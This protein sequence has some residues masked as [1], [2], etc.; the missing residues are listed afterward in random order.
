MNYVIVIHVS[1]GRLYAVSPGITV[2]ST[3][4]AELVGVLTGAAVM[5]ERLFLERRNP[6]D[7]RPNIAM[8]PRTGI[9]S[10]E[11]EPDDGQHPERWTI[12]TP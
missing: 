10:I 3:D 2:A 9:A 12:L 6:N 1:D 4:D 11:I 8:I 5:Q 7:A